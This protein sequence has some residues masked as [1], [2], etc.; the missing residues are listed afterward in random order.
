LLGSDSEVVEDGI[1]FVV[2]E[3]SWFAFFAECLLD[4]I[5]VF[6]TGSAL[7]LSKLTVSTGKGIL[8]TTNT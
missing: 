1:T 2:L 4:G 5:Q 7:L 8:Q 6:I 3:F